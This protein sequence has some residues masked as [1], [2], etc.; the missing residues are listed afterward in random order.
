MY[1]DEAERAIHDDAGIP[2]AL[3]ALTK[4]A[5]RRGLNA[6]LRL[7]EAEPVIL[8]ALKPSALQKEALDVLL[9]F[10]NPP[11]LD[12]IDGHAHEYRRVMPRPSARSFSRI[13]IRL[14]AISDGDLKAKAVELLMQLELRVEPRRLAAAS[15]PTKKRLVAFVRAH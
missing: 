9:A 7:G 14:L 8:A 10:T 15:S 1:P 5:S 3:P 6:C 12:R 2:E 4:R 13:S 11:R